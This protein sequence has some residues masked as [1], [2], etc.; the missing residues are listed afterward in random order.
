MLPKKNFLPPPDTFRLL[1]HSTTLKTSIVLAMAM[2]ELLKATSHSPCRP[3]AA[4]RQQPKKKKNS[5]SRT[6]RGQQLSNGGG[7]DNG[8]ASVYGPRAG[9]IRS[10]SKPEGFA[11]DQSEALQST[12]RI[13]SECVRT[14]LG[15]SADNNDSGGSRSVAERLLR[16]DMAAIAEGKHT[17]MKPKQLYESRKEYKKSCTLEVFRGHIYQ[18][19]K[20]RKSVAYYRSRNSRDNA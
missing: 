5:R 17:K 4:A 18:E 2:S 3:R 15:R 10:S 6:L 14:D 16:E 20:R 12:L 19:E 9:W 13:E 7:T 11:K 8:S 1:A